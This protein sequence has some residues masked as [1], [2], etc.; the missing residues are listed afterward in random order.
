MGLD[1]YA[2]HTMV[3]EDAETTIP[4]TFYWRKHAQL[5]EFMEQEWVKATG[6]PAQDLNCQHLELTEEILDR[7]E[8]ALKGGLPRSEG[9]FFFGHQFQDEQAKNYRSQ[10][11]KFLTWARECLA[12]GVTPAY[13]C[14]W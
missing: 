6:K 1:Q 3:T 10:D 7:F 2:G 8:K 14:W 13:S 9:G 11:L 5:Q 4:D 12:Q